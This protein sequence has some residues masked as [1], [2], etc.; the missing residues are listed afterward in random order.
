MA[1]LSKRA[2]FGKMAKLCE[3]ESGQGASVVR[4]C[5][6]DAGSSPEDATYDDY[7]ESLPAIR[8]R[9]LG[10]KQPHEVVRCLEAMKALLAHSERSASLQD[11]ITGLRRKTADLEASLAVPHT[12]GKRKK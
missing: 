2:L 10:H 7:R 3:L 11:V 12:Y 4:R 5:L 1:H 6:E 8:A 9:L